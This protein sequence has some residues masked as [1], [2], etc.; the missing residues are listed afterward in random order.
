VNVVIAGGGVAA[1]EATLALRALAE[2]RVAIELVAPESDFVY[3][4]LSVAEPFH[5]GE[6]R[7]FPL[8]ALA[9]AAGAR[10]SRQ[11]VVAVHPDRHILRTGDAAEI[12]Y[13][14]LLLAVGARAVEAVPKALTFRGSG[15]DEPFRRLLDS[16][17]GGAV[18][19]IAFA[20][21]AGVAWPLPAYELALMTQTYLTDRGAADIEVTI[22]TPEEAPLAVFGAQASTSLR[23]LL[24]VRGIVVQT[25][26]TPIAVAD[27]VLRVA[28]GRPVPADRVVALPRFEGPALPELPHDAHGF[29]PTDEFG[30]VTG[31]A[32]VYAA[33]DV[34]QFPL[35]QGGIATQQAD[36]AAGS[37][38][39]R[40]GA[41]VAPEPFR[42]VLR[43]LL[44]TGMVPRFLRATPGTAESVIDTAALW[45]PPAKIVGRY[46]APFL[47]SQLGLDAEPKPPSGAVPV[48][49][50][51][52][53][54]N[55]AL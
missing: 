28:A 8:A 27:G 4:P 25:H 39:A 15:S 47:A 13:D 50:E 38:A 22:V 16:A 6:A 43:G 2:E 17:L 31:L 18:H 37:I 21:P 46:F 51:L 52:D 19:R 34:T 12:E 33:G 29:V 54:S 42:P 23:S 35:K 32:D 9:K 40:A 5:A 30:L 36:A 45:W 24:D 20:I 11:Q 1:L 49:V 3:R 44:L 48:D 55:P 53:L 41:P 7:R 14:V 26:T 10:L